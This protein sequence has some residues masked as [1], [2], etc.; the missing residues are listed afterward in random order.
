MKNYYSTIDEVVLTFSDVQR[1]SDGFDF[2][3]AYFE[4]PKD[5]GFLYSKWILPDFKCTNS[6]GFSE[7]EILGQEDYLRNNILLLWE[8]AKDK[9]EEFSA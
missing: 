7:D 2:L 8:M 5:G 3:E 4:K 6:F 1:T 9:T